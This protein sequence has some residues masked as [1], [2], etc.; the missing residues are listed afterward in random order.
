MAKCCLAALIG[1]LSFAA[2]VWAQGAGQ[3][4]S[5]QQGAELAFE[6]SFSIQS[7]Q[8][9]V[10]MA[11]AQADGVRAQGRAQISAFVR[12]GTG[13][14]LLESNQIDNQY[15]IGFSYRIYDFGRSR[16]SMEAA[17]SSVDARRRA[18]LTVQQDIFMEYVRVLLQGWHAR[19]LQAA[20]QNQ[21]DTLVPRLKMA[22]EQLQANT[23][24]LMDHSRLYSEAALMRLNLNDAKGAE[25]NARVALERLVQRPG[26]C[27]DTDTLDPVLLG[28]RFPDLEAIVDSVEEDPRYRSLEADV[29]AA[30]LAVR[31]AS[32]EWM[33]TIN[34]SGFSSQ[35]YDDFRDE[36]QDRDRIGFEITAPL[37]DGGLR[38]SETARLQ[39]RHRQLDAELSS[40]RTQLVAQR[41]SDWQNFETYNENLVAARAARDSSAIY[42][43]ATQRRFDL[44]AATVDELLQAEER[45]LELE[46]RVLSLSMQ[47]RQILSRLIDY[48]RFFNAP[49]SMLLDL[50]TTR[51]PLED[52]AFREGPITG[53]RPPHMRR[54]M[55][56][57]SHPFAET[58]PPAEP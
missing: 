53:P 21:L 28:F 35:T 54:G 41:S 48:D 19:E 1:A 52:E 7:A 46:L 14:G 45:L 20:F 33:P 2:P 43:K 47:R 55:R 51:T 25:I 18:L 13:D 26:V 50:S 24:T 10:D 56:P 39:A 58:D 12:G 42:A 4:L 16:F 17:D 23:I 49:G 37:Y 32:R 44:R 3:C 11:N 57:R 9:Q 6:S 30:R 40:I 8:A 36:F 34:A 15:G 29:E 38:S 5:V 22:D 27:I 31:S